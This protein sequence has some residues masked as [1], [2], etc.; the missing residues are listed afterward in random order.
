MEQVTGAQS[1]I[2]TDSKGNSYVG[3]RYFLKKQ[4]VLSNRK[5]VPIPASFRY[6]Y[7]KQ[8]KS[9]KNTKRRLNRT[10]FTRKTCYL[11]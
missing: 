7:I 4:C 10:K 8:N 5:N 9:K 2:G 11:I 3:R 1:S 6:V